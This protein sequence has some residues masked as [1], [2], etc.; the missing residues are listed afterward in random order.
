[1]LRSAT[2]LLLLGMLAA[3]QDMGAGCGGLQPE[4]YPNPPPTGGARQTDVARARLTQNALN[5][6]ANHLDL[7]LAQFPGVEVEADTATFYLEANTLE[8]LPANSPVVP[9]A[10]ESRERPDNSGEFTTYPSRMWFSL[11]ELRD[12]LQV[13]WLPDDADGR[14]GLEL[15]LEDFGV[16]LDA[17]VAVDLGEVGAG[18]CRVHDPGEQ[19]A[20]RLDELSFALRFA[21][22]S[23]NSGPRVAASLQGDPVVAVADGPEAPFLE[24]LQVTPCDGSG[25]CSDPRC[26]DDCAN[27]CELGELATELGG[28]IS[29]VLNPLLESFAPELARAVSDVMADALSALPVTLEARVPMA[30]ILGELFAG[31]HDLNIAVA[32]SDNFGVSG[33]AA[34]TG[35]EL[36]MSGGAAAAG[37]AR[38]AQTAEPPALTELMGPPPDYTG[39]VEVLDANGSGRIEPYHV[40]AA[41]SEAM[42]AQASWSAFQT[43]LVCLDLDSES[44][45]S[46]TGGSFNFT[47]GLLTN[48]DVA[49]SD[50][51]HPGAPLLI[52]VRPTRAPTFALGA[53]G[54]VADGVEEPLLRT[55]VDNLELGI[56]MQVDQSLHRVSQLQADLTVD[57]AVERTGGN[58]LELAVDSIQFQNIEELY[59]ELAPRATLGEL[60]SVV[61]DLAVGSLLGDQLKFPLDPSAAISDAL[62]IP[63]FLRINAVRKDEGPSGARYLSLYGTLCDEAQLDDPANPSCYEADTG[64]AGRSAA[65]GFGQPTG[66]AMFAPTPAGHPEAGRWEAVP[67]GLVELPVHGEP[68]APLEYQFRVDGG[69]WSS[70]RPLIGDHVQIRSARLHVVGRHQIAI[71]TRRRNSAEPP[72]AAQRIAFWQD[73]E[74]PRLDIRRRGEHVHVDAF[75]AGSPETIELLARRPNSEHWERVESPLNMRTYRHGVWLSA[76]DAAGNRALPLP[77]PG[78]NG[79]PHANAPEPLARAAPQTG[80]GGCSGGPAPTL[81]TTL[82]LVGFGAARPRRRRP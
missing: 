18:V 9:T 62:G 82:I 56:Y 39:Y 53:G 24:T 2:S 10:G 26:G 31:V 54:P 16:F 33:D 34:G 55:V 46:L 14:P 80:R 30:D 67:S 78:P 71:R 6:F 51:T 58:A 52:T 66:R 36:G 4:P 44:V 77:L 21:L 79:Q 76:R 15:T 75:D 48:F 28:F 11:S 42:L 69:P 59:N 43:G 63:V 27:I 25:A 73:R 22:E 29:G 70:F 32:P 81:L 35:L 3:C 64:D 74:R 19:A 65:V 40:V 41:I 68:P 72:R 20:I 45:E 5:F 1:M 60:L 47:A 50:L 7:V 38:C 57:L 37:V 23:S 49:L 17:G 61:V 13:R 8:S 12:S